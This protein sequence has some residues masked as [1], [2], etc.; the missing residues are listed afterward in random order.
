MWVDTSLAETVSGCLICHF[1]FW[2]AVA[3]ALVMLL[4]FERFVVSFL[5][6]FVAAGQFVFVK[7]VICVFLLL[8]NL[9]FPPYSLQEEVF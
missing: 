3:A 8:L 7:A 2:F 6:T 9:Q 1:A 5:L 4:V